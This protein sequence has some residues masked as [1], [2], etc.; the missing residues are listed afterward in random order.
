MHPIDCA[1][2]EHILLK[3]VAIVYLCLLFRVAICNAK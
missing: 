3:F 2:Y 1:I